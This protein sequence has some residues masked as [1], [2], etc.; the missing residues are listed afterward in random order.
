VAG[1]SVLICKLDQGL[2]DGAIAL[3]KSVTDEVTIL[4]DQLQDQGYADGKS[5]AN[6]NTGGL[7]ST[8]GNTGATGGG[9]AAPR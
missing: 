4:T 1:A 5:T 9:G 6:A 8:G 7:Q 3:G 2:T